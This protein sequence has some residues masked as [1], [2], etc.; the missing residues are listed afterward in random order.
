LSG[1]KPADTAK[2]PARA[3]KPVRFGN[4]TELVLLLVGILL[5]LAIVGWMG[6]ILL[7]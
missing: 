6:N 3:T 4:Q 1:R 5:L 2:E 7:Q